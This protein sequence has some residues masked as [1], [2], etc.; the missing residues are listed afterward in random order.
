MLASKSVLRID[1]VRRVGRISEFRGI[2]APANRRRSKAMTSPPDEGP[3]TTGVTEIPLYDFDFEVKNVMQKFYHGILPMQEINKNFEM[4]YS[5]GIP[6]LIINTAKG[7]LQF[8]KD[9][10]RPI[11]I[12]VSYT[13]GNLNYYF[14]SED[15]LWRSD[16]DDHEL[17]GIVLR[18][19]IKFNKGM[20]KFD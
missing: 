14:N 17:R 19:L 18:D 1:F 2:I 10:T 8:I 12:Y 9:A 6:S 13:S 4:E 5:P 11:L 7:K 16:R 15:G 3:N 20:P